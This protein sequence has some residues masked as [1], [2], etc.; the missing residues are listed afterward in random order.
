MNWKPSLP[1]VVAILAGAMALAAPAAAQTTPDYIPIP[2][3]KSE[4]GTATI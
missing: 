1:S 2:Q 4:T 3:I